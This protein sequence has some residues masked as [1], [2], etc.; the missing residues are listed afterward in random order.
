MGKRKDG[1]KWC[2]KRVDEIKGGKHGWPMLFI[3]MF[4]K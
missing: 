1:E 3:S 4:S 2:I